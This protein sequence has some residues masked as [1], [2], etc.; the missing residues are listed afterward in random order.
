M[1]NGIIELQ[2]GAMQNILSDIKKQV[3]NKQNVCVDDEQKVKIGYINT[4]LEDIEHNM[5]SLDGYIKECKG[6]M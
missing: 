3:V 6:V 4:T 5:K 2:I 1:R